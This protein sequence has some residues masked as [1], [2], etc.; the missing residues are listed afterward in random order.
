[1]QPPI[2][3][4]SD[5]QSIASGPVDDAASG[6]FGHVRKR[7]LR[8]RAAVPDFVSCSRGDIRDPDGPTVRLIRRNKE[9]LRLVSRF[10]GPPHESDTLAVERPRGIGVGIH[11]RRDELNRFG[12]NVIDADEGVIGSRG[13]ESQT[14]SI[15]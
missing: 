11:R 12:G 9:T 14:A 13:H 3:F 10:G 6:I 1:M 8:R 7:S 4:R 2:F 15:G 5:D